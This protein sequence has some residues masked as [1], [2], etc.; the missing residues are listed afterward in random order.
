MVRCAGAQSPVEALHAQPRSGGCRGRRTTQT[1]TPRA[2]T[3]LSPPASMRP[4]AVDSYGAS[5]RSV[6][7]RGVWIRRYREEPGRPV[8]P[9]CRAGALPTELT[10]PVLDLSHA[11]T[12][13]NGPRLRNG[14]IRPPRRR[15][16]RD[17]R[18]RSV[19]PQS[20]SPRATC[21]LEL[22]AAPWPEIATPS[23]CHSGY[24]RVARRRKVYPSQRRW[25]R[26]TDTRS[27]RR[28]S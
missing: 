8:A 23:A 11:A 27:Q 21:T 19:S 12:P 17:R 14:Y 26:S 25:R 9:S 20:L 4:S 1:G 16:G 24:T 18:I 28:V 3:D 15:K 5:W 6:R 10:A 7:P 2:A 13:P 22:A